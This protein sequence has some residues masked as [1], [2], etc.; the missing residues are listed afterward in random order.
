MNSGE[1]KGSVFV[2][3]ANN[4]LFI[5]FALFLM[6]GIPTAFMPEVG[7]LKW[8]FINFG[9]SILLTILNYFIWTKQKHDSKRYFSLHSLVMMMGLAFFMVSPVLKIVYPTTFFWVLIIALIVYSIFLFS[10]YDAIAEG[11]LN[12]R[13][14]GF[15]LIMYTSF[16]ILFITGSS[17]WGYMLAFDSAPINVVAGILFFLGL[18]MILVAPAMLVTPKRAQEFKGQLE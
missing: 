1:L 4:R 5:T 9:V 7:Y 6:L 8:I 2:P 11:L 13:K 15:K 10:K 17:I 14:K 18:F 3:F 16:S 12:P